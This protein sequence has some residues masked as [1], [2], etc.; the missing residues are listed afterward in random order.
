MGGGGGGEGVRVIMG[1]IT[2]PTVA[3]LSGGVGAASR[4]SPE[5]N[6]CPVKS[7]KADL[8]AGSYKPSL[9]SSCY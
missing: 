8:S 2:P 1:L 5:L 3:I 4:W 6:F 9:E 7:V